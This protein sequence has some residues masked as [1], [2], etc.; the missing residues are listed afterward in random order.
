MKLVSVIMPYFKKEKYF[1]QSVNSVLSQSYKNL[2]V[3]IIDDELSL[4]SKNLLSKIS[5]ID[6]RI[7]I[8]SNPTNLGAG[9]SRNNGIKFSNGEF[10]A[11]CDCDDL[12]KKNKL[13][14]QIKFMNT[15][16]L[17]FSFTS[18]EIINNKNE[19]IGLRKAEKNLSFKKLRNSCDIGLSTVIIKK[20]IFDN[21]KFRFGETKTKEDFI[22]WL[23]LAKNGISINGIDECLTSWRKNSK[24]LSSS[25]IQKI[26]D[27]YKVYRNYLHYGRIKS[28]FF[29]IILSLNFMLKNIR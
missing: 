23:M 10:I 4:Q 7:K 18:Y 28:F 15:S 5:Q 26:I 8:I 19:K 27:G 11:F 25:S 20:N 6:T 22:L 1:E 2:E 14:E 29:L 17:E 3:I 9:L 13:E 24:S 12:W 21:E 16:N